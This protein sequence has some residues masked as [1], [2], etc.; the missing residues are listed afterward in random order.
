LIY[1]ASLGYGLVVRSL[2]AS[3]AN[4]DLQDFKGRSAL[5]F[6]SMYGLFGVVKCL[7][8]AGADTDLLDW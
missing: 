4:L 2:I 8:A 7:M 5:I 6:A 3:G 1:S